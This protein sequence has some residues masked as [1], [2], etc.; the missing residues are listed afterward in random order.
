MLN[1]EKKTDMRPVFKAWSLVFAMLFM[2]GIF[3]RM[4]YNPSAS[5]GIAPLL[6]DIN[7][8]LVIMFF[9][10]F[11]L[12][13]LWFLERLFDVIP[14]KTQCYMMLV[15]SAGTCYLAG[16]IA[17]GAPVTAA[18]LFLSAIG[19]ITISILKRHDWYLDDL[20]IFTIMEKK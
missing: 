7:I 11:A 1:D 6:S 15:L 13:A 17:F 20:L 16:Y 18:I 12:P 2:P 10:I 3:S 8:T 9:M 14:S 19:V 5:S 4:V